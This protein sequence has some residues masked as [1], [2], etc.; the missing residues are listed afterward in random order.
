MPKV[1]HYVTHTE[2]PVCSFR[3]KETLRIRRGKKPLPPEAE[4]EFQRL[5]SIRYCKIVKSTRFVFFKFLCDETST[6]FVKCYFL[7]VVAVMAL[8]IGKEAGNKS[9]PLQLKGNEAFL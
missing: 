5:N 3:R 8:L 9:N 4:A 1:S 2:C 6:H 7:V